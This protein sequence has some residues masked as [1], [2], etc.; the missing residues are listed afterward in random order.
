M[1][2]IA[3][4]IAVPAILVVSACGG[5][6]PKT[7][8]EVR[9]TLLTELVKDNQTI[10]W[11]NVIPEK[12]AGKFTAIVDRREGNAPD[13]EETLICHVSAFESS[14]TRYCDPIEPSILARS[15]KML[16]DNYKSRNL[17]VRDLQ[18]HRTGEGNKYGG[19]IVIAEP[20]SGQQ[21]KV[22]C[23][24]DQQGTDFS[25][26]CKAEWAAEEHSAT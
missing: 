11:L 13:S 7:A 8:E 10:P 14:S 5:G 17:V 19:Y 22:P 26:D 12:E 2:R 1:N 3:V 9:Q 6:K 4:L 23:R 25:I 24:G 21:A 16:A 20:K 15:A 18:L